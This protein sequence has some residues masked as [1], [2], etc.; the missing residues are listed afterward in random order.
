MVD[1]DDFSVDINAGVDK[2][3]RTTKSITNRQDA[4]IFTANSPHIPLM[5]ATICKADFTSLP[6]GQWKRGYWT[7]YCCERFCS[8]FHGPGCQSFIRVPS[9][10]WYLLTGFMA[11]SHYILYLHVYPPR[12]A[13]SSPG[14]PHLRRPRPVGWP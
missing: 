11:F 1:G 3:S 5:I 7:A 2:A 14:L 10:C 4:S 13:F 12:S 8:P 6:A 9:P